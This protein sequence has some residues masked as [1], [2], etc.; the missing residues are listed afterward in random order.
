[1]CLK[2]QRRKQTPNP[3][4]VRRGDEKSAVNDGKNGEVLMEA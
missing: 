2:A 1:M 4:F 3:H